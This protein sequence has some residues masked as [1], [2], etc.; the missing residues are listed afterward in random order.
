MNEDG[1][2][3]AIE[4]LRGDVSETRKN[5]QPHIYIRVDVRDST[6]V[7]RW[8]GCT[9]EQ[10]GRL[11]G[12]VNFAGVAKK[13]NVID[14]TDESWAVQMDVNAKGIVFCIRV[15]L[16][17]TE[18]GEGIVSAASVNGQVGW[19]PLGSYCASKHAII[20]LSRCAAKESPH[21]RVNCIA[22]GQSYTQPSPG[23]APCRLPR[24]HGSLILIAR[25]AQKSECD[26]LEVANVIAFLL[27]D[28]ASFITGAVW[29]VDDGYNC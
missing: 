28:E 27:G 23:L 2:V 20:G 25:Q 15:Q 6:S 29:N 14:E 21:I 19:E 8:I 17:H 16:K 1:L 10:L 12:A 11:D 13:V 9:V 7:N 3:K 4:S 5:Q 26:P 22:P 24:I 18:K